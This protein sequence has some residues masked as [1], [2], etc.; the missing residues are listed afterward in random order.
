MRAVAA[1]HGRNHGLDDGDGSVAGARIGPALQVMRLV[2]VPDADS[3]RLIHMRAE[4]NCVGDLVECSLELQIGGRGVERIDAEHHEPLHVARVHIGDE[5]F[6]VCNLLRRHRVHCLGVDD[7]LADVAQLGVERVRRCM[8]SGRSLF[9]GDHNAPASGL[10][11][12]RRNRR[13][14]PCCV[15]IR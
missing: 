15:G 10:F 6:E 13:K 11:Q 8:N 1:I 5:R 4:M 2:D 7:R 14:E 3:A 12:I 9:A